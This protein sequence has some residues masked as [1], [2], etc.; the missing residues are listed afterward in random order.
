[1]D[2]WNSW[3]EYREKV[4]SP[5]HRLV[6]HPDDWRLLG[7]PERWQGL[8]VKPLGVGAKGGIHG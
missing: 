6:V 2:R 1:M 7:K 5:I 8:P 4:L 3:I